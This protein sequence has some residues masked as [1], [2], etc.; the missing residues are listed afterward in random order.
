MTEGAE[1]VAA[2]DKKE[3]MV[4]VGGMWGVGLSGAV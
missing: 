2:V 3:K 1:I 4:G